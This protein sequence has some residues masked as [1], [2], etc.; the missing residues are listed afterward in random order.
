MRANGQQ[1]VDND[2][3]HIRDNADSA[4]IRPGHAVCVPDGGVEDG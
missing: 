2:S 1:D 3:K 4:R